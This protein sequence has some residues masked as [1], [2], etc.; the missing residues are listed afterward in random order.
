MGDFSLDP[1][2]GTGRVLDADHFSHAQVEQMLDTYCRMLSDLGYEPVPYPEPEARIGGNIFRGAK[3]DC[4]NHALWMCN[5]ARVF[6]RQGRWAKA[7]RWIGMVQ[8]LLLMGGLN[9]ISDLK[10]HNRSVV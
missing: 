10:R 7:H 1:S 3:Y 9:S 4:L 8:G 6:V 2:A 5:E